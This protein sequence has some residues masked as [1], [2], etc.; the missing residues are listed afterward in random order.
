MSSRTAKPD[1]NEMTEAAS[2]GKNP[3]VSG[4]HNALRASIGLFALGKD[5]V[6]AVVNRMVE[7]GELAE[8]DGRKIVVDLFDRPRKRVRRMNENVESAFDEQM[9]AILK[10]LNVPTQAD[11]QELGDKLGDL[12]DKVDQLSKRISS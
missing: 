6:E 3:V 1:T 7:R 8:K 9:N 12:A 11:L 10:T 2:N 5:E 4:V